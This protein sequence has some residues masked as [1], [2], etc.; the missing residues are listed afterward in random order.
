LQT[1]LLAELSNIKHW[2]KVAIQGRDPEG[3]HQLRISLRKMRSALTIFSPVIR[4]AYRQ[5]WRRRLKQLAKQL[6]A[7]RDLDVFLLTHFSG[8]ASDSQLYGA[9]DKKKARL[10]KQLCSTLKSGKFNKRRRQLKK[11]LAQT[12]W[13]K[14]YCCRQTLSLR[15]LAQQQLNTLYQNL[16]TQTQELHLNDEAALHQLRISFKQLRY[17]CEFLEPALDGT[18]S[19]SFINMMKALQDQLGD[20]HDAAVQ[21]T[22]LADLP[23][24]AQ[25]EFQ[26][27]LDESQRNSEHLKKTL[28]QQLRRF[29]NM[30][31]P[32][33]NLSSVSESG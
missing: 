27:I 19:Q 25:D 16:Q 24:A 26:T 23:V 14:K 31:P 18:T 29:N 4:P 12:N 6:D 1:L 10:Y 22:M 5:Q 9:L 30:P 3:V 8:T 2:R 21:Q 11:A 28:R 13:Q 32:W 7:A 15:S 20:I 33:Q 17:G